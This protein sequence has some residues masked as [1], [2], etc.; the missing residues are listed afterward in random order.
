MNLNGLT[1][2]AF[3]VTKFSFFSRKTPCKMQKMQWK[4]RNMLPCWT[5][6]FERLIPTC[7]SQILA[8][9]NSFI[10]KETLTKYFKCGLEISVWLNI[11]WIFPSFSNK[12]VS[13]YF[14][15]RSSSLVFEL[16]SSILRVHPEGALP[17]WRYW[18]RSHPD[19][20]QIS[21]TDA[22]TS[23]YFPCNSGKINQGIQ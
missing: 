3:L 18:R 7:W 17:P 21:L 16:I 5:F 1:V 19:P 11:K 2:K 20:L 14:R 15:L 12:L 10:L 23:G 13:S 22:G 6:N 4:H 9:S 8:C